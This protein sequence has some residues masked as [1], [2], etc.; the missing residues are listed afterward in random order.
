MTPFGKKEIVMYPCTQDERSLV[1][2]IGNW[3]STILGPFSFGTR[4]ALVAN[5]AGSR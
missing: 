2:Q 1:Y 4:L 3:S 5:E